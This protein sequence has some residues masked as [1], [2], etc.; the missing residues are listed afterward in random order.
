MTKVAQHHP[1]HLH[2]HEVMG[3]AQEWFGKIIIAAAILGGAIV[4]FG[5]LNS[6]GNVTW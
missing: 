4:L 3:K 5:A 1:H 6:H 2:A